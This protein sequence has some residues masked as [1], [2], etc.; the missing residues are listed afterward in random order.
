V[1]AYGADPT[2]SADSASAIQSAIN[3]AG[4]AGGGI[5]YFPS[6]VYKVNST[7]L[8]GDGTSL[9]VSTYDGVRLVGENGHHS[10]IS[11]H[12]PA[13][14]MIWG[15]GATGPIV[16]LNGPITGAGIEDIM[17]DGNAT[18]TSGLLSM[19]VQNARINHVTVTGVAAGPALPFAPNR[20]V[21]IDSY[22]TT[23]FNGG[24]I[25]GV[26]GY[27]GEVDELTILQVGTAG[28]NQVLLSLGET[29]AVAQWQFKGGAWRGDASTNST[30]LWLGFCDHNKFSGVTGKA[31][32]GIRLHPI[33][34][35][36]VFPLNNYITEG[37]SMGGSSVSQTIDTAATGAPYTAVAWTPIAGYPG[38]VLS[39]FSTVDAGSVTPTDPRF[40]GYNDQGQFFGVAAG[41]KFLLENTTTALADPLLTLQHSTTGTAAAGFGS[42][43][44]YR[45]ESDNGTMRDLA[46]VSGVWNS[47]VDGSRDSLLSIKVVRNAGS[48]EETATFGSAG[49][50]FTRN[51]NLV[52]GTLQSVLQLGLKGGTQSV[53][54]GSTLL[55]FGD[56]NGGNKEFMGRVGAVWENIGNGTEA[57]GIVFNSRNSGGADPFAQFEVARFT[58]A[59]R[60]GMGTTTPATNIELVTTSAG[61]IRVTAGTGGTARYDWFDNSATAGT[62]NRSAI[63]GQTAPGDWQ[64]RQSNSLGGDPVSAGTIRLALNPTGDLSLTPQSNGQTFAVQTLT[65]LTTIA[66]AATTDTTIQIP[67][68]S[69]VLA[70]TEKE[71][72]AI[73]TAATFTVTGV[74]TGAF[75]TGTNV[76]TALNT[77]NVGTKA[78]AF[79]SAT[80]QSVRFTPDLTPGTN[81]GRV[82]VTIHYIQLGAPTS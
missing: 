15:G 81:A 70:V 25:T 26:L 77:T 27:N 67:A 51:T 72:V 39:G 35:N 2:G 29:G 12:K 68:F 17:L 50:V 18:A 71:T 38:V 28:N 45:G 11:G 36:A 34:A 8:V 24:S 23:S 74:T 42:A 60:L 53:G 75:N 33:A 16:K 10:F 78:G 7:I 1:L 22:N 32:T 55:F 49:P 48:L 54:S 4:A 69:V 56:D 58:A 41:W 30:L 52:I 9:L 80:T 65:E 44:V 73:P 21:Q 13:V 47:P 63:T 3:A 82:R 37:S 40:I 5:V 20:V 61:G 6:G 76:S 19:H 43:L 59:G 62:R 31:E 64:L 57:A 14:R 46:S 66:A 79:Y